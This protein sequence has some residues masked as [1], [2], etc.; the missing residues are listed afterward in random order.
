MKAYV[1]G[2]GMTR[3][4][5]P[6][7]REWQYWDMVR[8][9][10]GAALTDAGI[11]YT[12]VEQ[13]P[14]GYCFQPSTA[15]QRAVY[16]LGLTGIPVYN[17]NNNCATGATALMLAG[18]LV[19]GG[20]CDCV[21]A[22]GF[23]KMKR[24]ALGGGAGGGDFSTSPVARHYGVMAARHGFGNTPP[25]AQIF[26]AAAR[27]HIERYGT[28]EAQLAAV[29]AKNHRHSAHNPYA[30]FRD[31]YDVAG[32]LAAPMVHRPLTRLQCSPTSDGAAAAVVVSERFAEARA[33]TGL[34]E[35]AGQAM[36]TDTEESFSSGSCIDAVGRP[37]SRE[38]A[39]QAYERAGFGI[40]DVDVIELH[41]CFSV[42]ELLT[43]EAL[44]MCAPEES[45][46][47]AESG[48]T[49][50]GGRWVV[51][52]SGGLISKGHPLGATGLAQ[53]A[54]LV[55]QLRGDAG[56]RQVPGARV[57]LA[58]NIGLGGA[59]VVTLLRSVQS[60]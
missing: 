22:L 10:G 12:D 52:P 43:Y 33:L 31:V 15:G 55:W 49:T 3:F 30:Q 51:N 40:E 28:T 45:G 39:R 46:K 44:G 60:G 1:A 17:V 9:A 56:E 16:E 38:A 50:Y 57:G 58:H 23:E 24:G 26:A 14:V 47:L 5:K 20:V 8:E 6:E 53:I 42:N 4:E 35:L 34:V 7:T 25:T 59:A 32:V 41:D 21:L 11:T 19:A 13:V 48:A 37:M 27:E 2:V 54:E 36:T 18:Q 29:A